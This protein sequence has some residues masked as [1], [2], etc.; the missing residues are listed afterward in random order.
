[1]DVVIEH[2]SVARG[3]YHPARAFWDSCFGSQAGRKQLNI[4]SRSF[5][6]KMAE[7]LFKSRPQCVLDQDQNLSLN[8]S[9]VPIRAKAAPARAFWDWDLGGQGLGIQG[10]R[11]SVMVRAWRSVEGLRFRVQGFRVSGF[12]F[13]V[14]GLDFECRVSGLGVRVWDVGLGV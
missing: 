3:T 8:A 11:C 2:A 1:M 9:C 5:V 7:N 14:P 12:G 6:L 4:V 13:R 10:S